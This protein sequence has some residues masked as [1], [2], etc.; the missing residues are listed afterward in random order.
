MT[1]DV[2]KLDNMDERGRVASAMMR[3]TKRDALRRVTFGNQVA[4]EEQDSL[5]EYFVRTQAW[6]RIYNGEIDIIYGPKGAGK[7]ALYVL[8]QDHTNQLFDRRVLLIAAENPRG[9]PAF[10]DL[11]TDPP[12]GEREFAGIWK[13]YFLSLIARSFKE[14]GIA[15]AAS[16]QV[17]RLLEENK[18]LPTATTALGSVLSSVRGYIARLARP[19][20]SVEGGVHIEPSSGMMTYSGKIVFDD[21]DIQ[22][23]SEG[24]LSV[25]DLVRTAAQALDDA[26]YDVWLTVD[27][28]DVAFDESSEL[29]KNALRALFRVYR[30]FRTHNRI[31]IKIFLRTD[32]W[33]RITEEG[34]REAT[35]LSRDV[36]ITWNKPALH[37]LIV[38]RLLN[39]S[40]VID[41]YEL[42]KD[43]ILSSVAEQETLF[44]R[45][46]PDQVEI[47]EKQSTTIDWILKR[48][49]DATNESQPRDIILFLNKLCEVQNQRLERG[50]PEP[51]GEWLFD[52]VAFKEALPAL[53]EYRIGRVLF[54]EYPAH[55][56]YIEALREQKTEQNVPSLAKLWKVASEKALTIAKNLRDIGFFEE[57]TS[58]GEPTFWVPFVYRPYL[59]MSQGKADEIQQHVGD[60]AADD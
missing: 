19:P 14:Y 44:K 41:L 25:D 12:T 29:E 1:I 17:C 24:F 51:P 13:L 2:T 39:N 15:N 7:S 11:E 6:E 18:L 37:N 54:A 35:H 42:K 53:S 43:E 23:Q 46:F 31:K 3:G 49:A 20:K 21:P 8:I 60:Q 16:N 52:R 55:R 26:K 27:R 40:A 5:R 47:G 30:D 50:E 34:F 28:L 10:K 56:K 32:I 4:E 48:T 9:T 45:L 36:H 58:R 57:R 59:S 33:K 22:K 38:R